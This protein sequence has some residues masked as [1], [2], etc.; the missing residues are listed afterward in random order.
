MKEFIRSIF[1]TGA[2]F[3]VTQAFSQE[4]ASHGQ[5]ADRYFARYQYVKAAEAYEKMAE[6]KNVKPDVY[7]KLGRAY[8]AMQQYEK[9]LKW[10]KLYCQKY[11]NADRS[12]LLKIGELHKTLE[13]YDNASSVFREYL[14]GP[15]DAKL[16]KAKL[17]GCDSALLWLEKPA[18]DSI[19]NAEELNSKD[20]DWGVA[21]YGS[22][23]AF[24]SE[25]TRTKLL[26]TNKKAN[27]DNY[28]W[29]DRPFMKLY[30]ATPN[31][32]AAAIGDLGEVFNQN[33]YHVGPVT[34]SRNIDTAYFTVTNPGND[35]ALEYSDEKVGN[36]IR[37][38]GTRKLELYY[39][40]RDTAGKWRT[41]QPFKYNNAKEYSIG[42]AALD[43]SGKI[44]YYVSDKEGSLG[45]TDIWYSVKQTDGSWGEPQNCGS[46]INTVDE[47][48][49][50]TFGPDGTFYFASKGHPGMGGYDIF[51][52]TGTRFYW[53]APVN[54][55][56]PFNSSYDDFYYTLTGPNAGYLS[57]NRLG[58][59]G[60]DDIYAFTIIPGPVTPTPEKEE[61]PVAKDPNK[62]R[63][64]GGDNDDTDRPYEVGETLILVNV[65]YDLD[66]YNIRPDAARG[67]DKLV[68]VLKKY[69][70]MEIELSSHTDSRASAAYN[71][72]LSQNRA[73]AAV[74]YLESKGIQ[75]WRVK[76]NGYGETRLTNGCKDGVPCTEAEHQANRRTEVTILKR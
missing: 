28:D 4:Q 64:I 37:S 35:K 47:E 54:L 49:F 55:K 34:F 30:Q 71:M 21:A 6:K 8:E 63:T 59:K 26:E 12:I 32:D 68:A 56:P 58:G 10:Y 61:P 18:K 66:K 33:M 44:L 22:Q 69:P 14:A 48:S 51:K 57:S 45:K 1:I 9:A 23:I 65:Y 73:I 76:A 16:A 38:I 7:Y 67:L 50:P 60:S 70:T 5:I 15:G 13:Q 24:T 11:P 29:T 17:A 36:L 3:S 27:G 52:T 74:N 39:S 2:L 25:F 19:R 31:P 46:K 75:A 62:K 43:P 72:Q 40:I 20:A 53:T 41:A 42:L